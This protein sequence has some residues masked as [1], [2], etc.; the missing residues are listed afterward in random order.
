MKYTLVLGAS[1]K[2]ERYSN[3]AINQLAK[4]GHKVLAVGNKEGTAHGIQITKHLPKT[5]VD[6][7]TVYL[8]KANQKAYYSQLL[9]LHPRRIIF[10]PGA[11]NPELSALATAKGIECLD[12]CTL[13][14][15][16]VGNY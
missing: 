2:Q 4:N 13:V 15:L 10:N 11:E 5:K 12:A 1:L 9:E 14:L 7:I 8:S 6:T 16:S 3:R